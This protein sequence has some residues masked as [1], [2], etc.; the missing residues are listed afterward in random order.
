VEDVEDVERVLLAVAGEV[1]A[2]AVDD[3][4]ADVDVLA[5]QPARPSTSPT[6]SAAAPP[7]RPAIN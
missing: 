1:A 3:V 4:D 6:I 7:G 5:P 2:G